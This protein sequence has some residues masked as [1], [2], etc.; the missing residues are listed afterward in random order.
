MRLFHEEMDSLLAKGAI[1]PARRHEPRILLECDRGKKN[2]RRS[3]TSDLSPIAELL[4]KKEVV[5]QSIREGD[6]AS[7]IDLKDTYLHVPLTTSQSIS[8]L[9]A[10]IISETRIH[11]LGCFKIV[12]CSNISACIRKLSTPL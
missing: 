5:S 3:Q 1:E 8:V 10:L 4:H 9:H 7:T 2:G 12:L 11:V 6:S